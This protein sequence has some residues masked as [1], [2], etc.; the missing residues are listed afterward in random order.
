MNVF[1]NDG[2]SATVEEAIGI[3]R[4]GGMLI[5]VDDESRE[6]E[7]DLVMAAEVADTRS[8]NFMISRAKGLVCVPLSPEVAERLRLEPMVKENTD[9]HCTA[10]T[11]SVD[12]R[13]GTTTGISAEERAVTARLL[14][15]PDALPD[16]FR[17]PGHMFP[18]VSRRGGVLKRAGHTEAAVDL[19]RRRNMRDHERRRNHGPFP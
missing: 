5:V 11:V 18:L 8:I 17:K 12:A 16:M 1:G 6:N 13:E 4:N 3:V 2:V 9:L 19:A 14:S 7:G 15:D 10:F